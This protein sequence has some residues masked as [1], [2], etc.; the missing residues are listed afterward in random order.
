MSTKKK[1]TGLST[2]LIY[3][4]L[5]LAVLYCAA[6]VGLA[7]DRSKDENEKV[8]YKEL[9]TNVEGSFLDYEGIFANIKDNETYCCKF[10]FLCGMFVGIYALI[11]YT[12]KKR[13]HRKGE[14]HGSAR[15]ATEA[16]GKKLADKKK[17]KKGEIDNNIILTQEVQMSLN[18]RQHRENLNVLVIG[19][20]G[21][22]KSR[23]YVKPNIM[24]LNTSYVVTD[25]KG[26]RSDRVQ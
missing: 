26:V 20:S 25:P 6:A 18:T 16:E 15:W 23:F 13:L 7:F 5:A 10:T 4:C 24:Q 14:E 22:G 17:V 19:G 8:D 11:K 1:K 9:L 12:S 2:I 21:S 3:L